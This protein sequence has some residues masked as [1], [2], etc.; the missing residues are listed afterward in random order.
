MFFGEV[1]KEY[2]TSL[3]NNIHSENCYVQ[4]PTK[5]KFE[6][7]LNSELAAEFI[8][9]TKKIESKQENLVIIPLSIYADLKCIIYYIVYNDIFKII[10]EHFSIP[11]F[12]LNVSEL[13]CLIKPP[14]DYIKR[15]CEFSFLIG[16]G[17]NL[18]I[19]FKNDEHVYTLNN[20]DLIV[21]CGNIEVKYPILERNQ[22]LIR[23]NIKI[24]SGSNSIY[25]YNE[26]PN[27]TLSW[28]K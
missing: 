17:T 14:N 10:A 21:Y 23:G 4:Y 8:E 9:Y 24:M 1:L 22:Y 3:V 11:L 18:Q 7:F 16:L 20:L 28:L 19:Q 2:K 13:D 27:M 6:N 26:H 5:F 15:N 25:N 12:M